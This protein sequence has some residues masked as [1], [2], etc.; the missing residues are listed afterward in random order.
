MKR[1]RQNK[2]GRKKVFIK[3]VFKIYLI[4]ESKMLEL[5]D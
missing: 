1:K 2:N 3:L 4:V 5:E